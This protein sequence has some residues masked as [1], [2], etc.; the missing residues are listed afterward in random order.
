MAK[1]RKLPTVPLT[2]LKQPQAPDLGSVA[3]SPS[4][5]G[6]AADVGSTQ[7]ADGNQQS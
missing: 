2:E 3:E 1:K 6:Q 7:E 4:T 5:S